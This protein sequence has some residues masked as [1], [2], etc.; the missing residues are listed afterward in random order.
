MKP[1]GKISRFLNALR[2]KEKLTFTLIP[3][4]LTTY[5][6]SIGAVYL[7]SF[8]ETKNIVDH[9]ASIV[10]NQKIQLVDSYLAQLRTE[11]EVFMFDTNFQKQLRTNRRTLSAAQQET[12]NE[13]IQQS[14]HSMIISYDVY[15]ES[16]TLTNSYGDQYVWRMDS[17]LIYS[18]FTDRM[19]PLAEE[20]RALDGG[21]LYSYDK[22]DQGVVTISRLIKD[23]IYDTEIGMMMIDFN[24][25]FLGSMTSVQTS[26]LGTADVLLAI[27]NGAGSAVYNSSP[28]PKEKLDA[29]SESTGSLPLNGAQYKINRTQ[30]EHNDWTLYTIINETELYR[31]MNG[32]FFA[33]L[34]LISSRSCSFSS[35]SSSFHAS[36]PG[37]SSTS[38]RR[39][40][41]RP[42]PTGRH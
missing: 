35:R 27:T 1:D 17:R 20:T 12:L 28:V 15:V 38:S 5:L 34:S 25:G 16:I 9:Q 13:S 29:L 26:D 32:I 41:A 37:S 4:I 22:L 3:V 30:S 21:I 8:Q 42:H 40:A 14:M 36:S 7:S 31:N 23:P 39:C 33:Q 24:L 2:I 11:S 6:I 19:R 18:D 10:A